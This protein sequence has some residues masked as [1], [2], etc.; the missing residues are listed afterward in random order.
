V[1]LSKAWAR[2][3]IT[4]GYEN[5]AW[6]EEKLMAR[7]NHYFYVAVEGQAVVGYAFG[8]VRKGNAGPVISADQ[9]YLEIFEVYIQPEHRSQGVGKQL[10]ES[11]T[12]AAASPNEY[13]LLLS[14]SNRNWQ[15]TAHFYEQLGFQMW[16]VQMYI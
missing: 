9:P 13:R 10:W 4:I 7:L 16:Y 14:S 2:E 3:N 5:V 1:A 12:R 15:D 6:T 11:L 8:E